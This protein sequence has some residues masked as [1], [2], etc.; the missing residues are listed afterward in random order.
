MNLTLQQK[1]ALFWSLGLLAAALLINLAW[2]QIA[3]SFPRCISI[4]Q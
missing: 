4:L 1:K 3:A 2:A